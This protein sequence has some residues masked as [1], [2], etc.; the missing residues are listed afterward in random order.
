[1]ITISSAQLTFW[2]AG[3]LWPLTRILG[4]IAA[5]PILGHASVPLRQKVGLGLIITLILAPLL[6]PHPTTDPL[7][8]GGVLIVAEQFLI[9]LA[10][11]F[12]MRVVFASIEMAGELIALTMALNFAT[13]YDPQSQGESSVV[14]Q[15][16][17]VLGTLTF[18]ALDGHLLLLSALAE[19]FY[20]LPLGLSSLGGRGAWQIA[21]WGSMVFASGVQL[22]L[23]VLASLLITLAALGI[24]SRAAP[25]LNIF[26]V[27]F[28]ISI[29]VGLLVIGLALPSLTIP[30][31]QV[32]HEG[33]Q[34]INRLVA[35]R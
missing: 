28:P 7:S 30:L 2:V 24:L 8:L 14:S 4:L 3:L 5:A 29:G 34:V 26:G 12:A 25:Q 17:L 21:E 27:G 11:G 6:P 35:S 13:L 1:M 10:M 9:G 20:T 31:G 15:F 32:F 33:I 22:S 19:S 23:P 16:L 18:L